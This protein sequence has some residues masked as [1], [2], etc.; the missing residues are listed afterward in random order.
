MVR[1]RERIPCD[2]PGSVPLQKV[3]VQQQ[4]HQLGH[5]NRGMRVVQLN[6]KFLLQLRYV[7]GTLTDNSNCVLQ[8]AGDEKVLLLES[9]DFALD[10]FVVRIQHLRDVL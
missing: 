7:G 2:F 5:G 3:F 10:R 1:I 9:K 8:G 4:P 6:D